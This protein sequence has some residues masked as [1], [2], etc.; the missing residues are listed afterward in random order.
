MSDHYGAL[1]FPVQI[2]DVKD[3]V[4]DPAIDCLGRYLQCCL[5]DQ[6]GQ[7]WSAVNP[8]RKFVESIQTNSPGDAFNEKDLPALFL[9]RQSTTDERISDDWVESLSDVSIT[10]VPQNAVQAKRVLRFTGSNGLSKV[11]SRALFLGR[12][13]AWVDPGDPDPNARTLGSVLINR[14]GLLRWPVVL[15]TKID[16]VTIEK[17]TLVDVYPAY[18]VVVRINEITNWDPSFDSVAMADRPQTK[19]DNSITSGNFNISEL[20]PLT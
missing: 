16:S 12:S 4:H 10:W 14:A 3:S 15:M 13:P 5:N 6:L 18:T 20:I 1:E 11:I 7:S 2:P 17:G 19:L 8:G 9:T